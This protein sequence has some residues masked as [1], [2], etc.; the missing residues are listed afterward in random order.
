MYN[1]TVFKIFQNLFCTPH[2]KIFLRLSFRSNLYFQLLK[3]RTAS[4]DTIE[5]YE[6]LKKEN[7]ALS[8][9]CSTRTLH[10]KMEISMKQTVDLVTFTEEILN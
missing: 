6:A 10:K 3:V 2:I 4:E 1:Q 9:K 8:G 7:R 5:K